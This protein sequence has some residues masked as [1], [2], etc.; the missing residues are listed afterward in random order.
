VAVSTPVKSLPF[1]FKPTL[2]VEELR[3]L[4]GAAG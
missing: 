2:D 4:S 3:W 1:I